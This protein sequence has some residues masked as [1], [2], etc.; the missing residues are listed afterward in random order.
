MRYIFKQ[1]MLNLTGKNVKESKMIEKVE[2]RECKTLILPQTFKRNNGLCMICL[3]KE[4]ERLW[5]EERVN[6]EGCLICESEFNTNDGSII[7]SLPWDEETLNDINSHFRKY[8]TYIKFKEEL[9]SGKLYQCT[10]CKVNWFNP[11]TSQNIYAL[12]DKT[13]DLLKKWNEKVNIPR[14][15]ILKKLKNIGTDKFYNP[16]CNK[17]YLYGIPCSVYTKE[18]KIE[19]AIFTFNDTPP[20]KSS[21]ENII[22]P[23]DII[24][25]EPSEFAMSL[26][27]RKLTH[28]AMEVQMGVAPTIVEDKNGKLYGI[29]YAANF[30]QI[31]T[32]KGVNLIDKKIKFQWELLNVPVYNENYNE[33]TEVYCELTSSVINM[34]TE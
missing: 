9:I 10:K 18:K 28:T 34:L 13:F 22:F 3:H 12:T 16:I 30:F 31:D 20:I 26:F 21:Y 17:T 27:L 1:I 11:N 7:H 33:I 23:E 25:V 15:E 14:D 2:C 29:N 6:K 19:K 4:N 32:I 8:P 5:L 24:K